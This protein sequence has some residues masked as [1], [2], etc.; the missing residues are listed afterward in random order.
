MPRIEDLERLLQ[1]DPNDAFTLYAIANEHAK[2]GRTDDSCAFY[3]R[4]LAADPTYCYAYYHKAKAL[5]AGG[6]VPEAVKC[7]EMGLKVARKLNDF[8]AG[9]ELDALLMD[10]ENG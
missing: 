9:S 2:A 7:V 5:Q 1:A 8:K 10:L 3:D 4:C 6:R